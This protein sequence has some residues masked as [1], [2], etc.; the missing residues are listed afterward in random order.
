MLIF[1]VMGLFVVIPIALLLALSFFILFAVRKT[2]EQGLKAFGYVI[3]ALLWLGSALVFSV[4]VYTVSTGRHPMMS[5][6]Q[7]M[8]RCK[9][10]AM[11][12]RYMPGYMPGVMP[13]RKQMMMK[14]KSPAKPLPQTD[15]PMMK[16]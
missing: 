15:E 11:T 3:A 8:A 6:M 4:G 1:R 9:M 2:Q 14:E 13:G 7:E 5:L 10:Q 12:P 16:R